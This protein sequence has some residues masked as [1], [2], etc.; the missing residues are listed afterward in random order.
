LLMWLGALLAVSMMASR[1]TFACGPAQYCVSAPNR[2]IGTSS[3]GHSAI[4]K[5]PKR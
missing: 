3:N 5:L 4:T 1:R 2:V